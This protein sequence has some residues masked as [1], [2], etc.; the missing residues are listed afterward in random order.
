MQRLSKIYILFFI[1]LT[2]LLVLAI[3]GLVAADA[4]S[5]ASDDFNSFN[6]DTGLW[7]FTD[8]AGDAVMSLTGTNTTDA[9]LSIAVPGG[10]I[11]DVWDEGN[12]APRVMQPSL[13]NDFGI[14]VK[15]DSAL[16]G[17]Q[18]QMQGVIVE[19]DST[20]FLRFDFH[21]NGSGVNIFAAS[22][23]GGSPSAQ[24]PAT[25]IS[26]SAPFYMRITRTGDQWIQAYSDDGSSWTTAGTFTF[27]LNVAEVGVFAGNAGKA[28][29]HTA[30][31]DYFFNTANRIDPEDGA[32]GQVDTTEPL[33]YNDAN[34]VGPDAIRVEWS[35]DEVATATVQYGMTTAYEL[36]QVTDTNLSLQHSLLITGLSPNTAYNY[37]ILS[38]DAAGNVAESANYA[39]TTTSGGGQ[40]EPVIDVWYGSDQN[41]G[42]NGEPQ[43]WVNILGRVTDPEG[44]DS[45]SYTLNGGSPAS[46][47]IG[48][49]LHRLDEAGDFNIDLAYDD[50]SPGAN[51]IVITATDPLA[52]TAV[53]TVTVQYDAGNVWPLP[54]AID[55]STVSDI[56]DVAQPVDGKWLKQTDSIRVT[57]DEIGYDR[58]VAIGDVNWTD[59]QIEV[60][61]TV[62]GIQTEGIPGDDGPPAVGFLMRWTGHFD[63]PSAPTSPKWGYDPIGGLG[64]A[65]WLNDG[66]SGDVQIVGRGGGIIG[67]ITRKLDFDTTYI[68]KMRVET[69]PGPTSYYRLKIWEQGQAEPSTWDV[70]GQETPGSPQHGSVLLLAHH[71]DASFGDVNITFPTATTYTLTVDTVGNGS[72]TKDPDKTGYD[73]GETVTLTATA[74]SGYVFDSWS[75]DLSGTANPASLMMSSNKIV[76]ATFT[77]ATSPTL[78]VNIVGSGVVT[79]SPDKLL[80]DYGE[81]VSL[82]ADPGPGYVFAGWSGDLTGLT[83]PDTITLNGSKT[84]TATFIE[85]VDYT[86][87]VN[88]SPAGSGV[89][90]RSPDQATYSYGQVVTLTATPN[91]GWLFDNW[92]GDVTTTN[93]AQATVTMTGN[94]TVTANFAEDTSGAS[95]IVSDDFNQCSLNTSVWTFYDP[96]GDGSWSMEDTFTSDAQ[97]WLN[98]PGGSPHDV[99]NNGIEAPHLMQAANNTDFEIEVK[100]D[101]SVTE[102]SIST[103]MQ[104]VLVKQDDDNFLRF[105]FYNSGDET[106]IFAASFESG[107]SQ[108]FNVTNIGL[109]APLYMRINRTGDVWTVDYSG[110]G[111]SWTTAG[112]FSHA[113]AVG[114]VGVWA[115]NASSSFPAHT[116]KVDYFFNTA[117]PVSPE[118]GARNTLTVQTAGS[119]NV[120]KS[121]DKTNYICEEQ[122]TLDPEAQ[123]GWK[124]SQW[125]GDLSGTA[126]PAVVTM[127]GSR[128]ITATF[129]EENTYSLVVDTVGSG[130]VI[131]N[132]DK[133]SYNAGET[134]TLTAQ[135]DSGYK[136]ASWSGVDSANGNQATVTMNSNRS[137][138]ATF[139]PDSGGHKVY[140]PLVIRND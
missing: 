76:T 82:T 120:S 5:F 111:S 45:L 74:A 22:I 129:I 36:G 75:G 60:P 79:R 13:D 57:G 112:S 29:A 113:L 119:G 104:G 107:F 126:D 101:S 84:V 15:F 4:N 20:N 3:P 140:L 30:L 116:A 52:N 105:D 10:T 7:T 128:S 103:R 40:A 124:F 39:V 64:W 18:F 77:E 42:T 66:A 78:T 21:S 11:H 98:V 32:T 8:P 63:S 44:I 16:D 102:T 1:I 109:T 12:Q 110:N 108:L 89:V 86:L 96:K 139:T 58:L 46:L 95:G 50:L 90:A 38:G 41:F 123:S 47:N 51:Q 28:P 93:G 6:L 138:T 2:P 121:P 100:F 72:V 54:Y 55:W 117:S 106:N 81:E 99:Y 62:H 127:L 69:Q 134:V 23:S 91:S 133:P 136:F 48:P 114:S 94:K 92:S 53:E 59:Y 49:D 24:V 37:K 137:V 73:S 131:K 26:V 14:E 132:P 35:T 83:N 70:E 33:L 67:E 19:Q 80:Y 130:S 43:E 65:R 31:V 122:V 27:A 88:A 97:F 25:G 17:E 87:T 9:R 135:A 85:D 71:A 125:S 56:L 34:V 118:D 115:G 68:F 61:V